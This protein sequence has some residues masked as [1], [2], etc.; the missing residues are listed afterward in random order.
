MKKSKRDYLSVNI[1]L[2]PPKKMGCSASFSEYQNNFF[3]FVFV[4]C[5]LQDYGRWQM[6]LANAHGKIKT[7][8]SLKQYQ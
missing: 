7:V 6:N 4:F 3:N 2:I 8:T 5:Y 1:L